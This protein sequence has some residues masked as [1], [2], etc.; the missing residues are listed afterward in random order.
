MFEGDNWKTATTF[1]VGNR[2]KKLQVGFALPTNL[3][4]LTNHTHVWFTKDIKLPLW[5]LESCYFRFG[6]WFLPYGWSP[7]SGISWATENKFLCI[8]NWWEWWRICCLVTRQ[9]NWHGGIDTPKEKWMYAIPDFGE[10]MT[11]S[12]KHFLSNTYPNTIS[13]SN[14]CSKPVLSTPQNESMWFSYVLVKQYR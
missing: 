13:I 8:H 12:L 2:K 3:K 11:K 9:K 1:L 6:F 4:T 5:Q 14:H 10:K 7:E